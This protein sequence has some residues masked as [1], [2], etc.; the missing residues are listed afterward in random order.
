MKSNRRFLL[1]TLFSVS[2][3]GLVACGGGGGGN[4]ESEDRGFGNE[5][6]AVA[7]AENSQDLAI[8][9]EQGAVWVV[10]NPNS[11]SEAEVPDIGFFG[12]RANASAL[13]SDTLVSAQSVVESSNV[14]TGTHDVSDEACEGDG[15]AVVK[16]TDVN[17]PIVEYTFTNCI[18][19]DTYAYETYIL[20]GTFRVNGDTTTFNNFRQEFTVGDDTYI[21]FCNGSTCQYQSGFTGYNS[22]SYQVSGQSVT[23]NNGV[24]EVEARVYDNDYG[25]VDISSVN[26]D[27]NFGTGHPCAGSITVTAANSVTFS[28]TFDSC[29]DYTVT[30][31]GVSESYSW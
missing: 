16:I 25:Y 23:Y 2:S 21:A 14:G 19:S 30:F 20:N 18:L 28:V 10:E 27:Y 9:A 3:F 8:A 5:P 13:V 6:A 7:T 26:F 12:A 29:T 1:A 31:N 22:K 11:N 4:D 15:K 24:Y 17:K